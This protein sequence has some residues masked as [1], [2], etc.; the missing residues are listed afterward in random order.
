MT[1]IPFAYSRK[2]ENKANPPCT[3][4]DATDLYTMQ[5]TRDR[6]QR[7]PLLFASFTSHKTFTRFKGPMSL[8]IYNSNP[9]S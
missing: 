3:P 1:A 2:G 5:A 4:D 9:L 6:S 7:H 8:L